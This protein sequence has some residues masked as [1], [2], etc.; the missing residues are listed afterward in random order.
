MQH[1]VWHRGLE[2]CRTSA[3]HVVIVDP[4]ETREDRAIFV[5]LLAD[6]N[7]LDALFFPSVDAAVAALD[8]Y[9]TSG[10]SG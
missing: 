5:H 10:S 1:V 2:I 3:G 8:E 6:T 9:A 7:S 4:S